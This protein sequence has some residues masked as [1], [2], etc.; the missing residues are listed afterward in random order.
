MKVKQLM[1]N[2][3]VGQ[4]GGPTSVINASLKGIIEECKRNRG[5]AGKLFGAVNGIEGILNEEIVDLYAEKKESI[6]ALKGTPGAALGGCR[7]MIQSDDTDEADIKRIFEV[8]HKY[9]IRYFFYIGGNDSMDTAMKIDSAA[10]KLGVDLK[11]IGVPKTIDNDLM[12]TDHSPG[13][14]SCARYLITSVIESGLHA[15]SMRTAEPVTI[16]I[17]VG[18]N[19]GWLP[20]ACSLA[21]QKES[22]PPHILCFPEVVFERASFAK[23]VKETYEKFGFVYIVTGEGLKDKSGNYISAEY[24]ALSTDAFGHPTLGGAAEALQQIVEQDSGMKARVI[25]LDICQQAAVHL[26]SGT[27]LDEAEKC[28]REAVKLALHGDTGVM[29][30]M[31]RNSSLPY[32]ISYSKACLEKIANIDRTLSPAFIGSNGISVTEAFT[33][34]MRPLIGRPY[35]LQTIKSNLRFYHGLELHRVHRTGLK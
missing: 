19:A 16:L 28:G 1:G 8:F 20:A 4:S 27:D 23:A 15:Y 11:V 2:A 7:Y 17:T 26:L 35:E 13:Y 24:D 25:K 21:R 29:V 12:E 18:R 22:D 33:T 30:T 31:L 6:A 32:K 5:M 10:K 34:Y 3:I 9:D 14:G